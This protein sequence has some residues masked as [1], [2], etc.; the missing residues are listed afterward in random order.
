MEGLELLGD[1]LSDPSHA[2]HADLGSGDRAR[3]RR[4]A[5]PHPTALSDVAVVSDELARHREEE[6]DRKIGDVVIEDAR[7]IADDHAALLGMRDVDRVGADADGTDDLEIRERVDQRGVGAVVAAGGDGANA[8]CKLLQKCVRVRR[9]V[10]LVER[11][12]TRERLH[13][14]RHLLSDDEYFGLHDRS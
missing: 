7:R 14:M 1:R 6:G 2:E 12:V 10:Q 3:K 8:R 9:L 4:Q 5:I 11:V 13:D